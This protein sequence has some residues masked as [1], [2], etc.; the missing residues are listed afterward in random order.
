[1]EKPSGKFITVDGKRKFIR[2]R[3]TKKKTGDSKRFDYSSRGAKTSWEAVFTPILPE[4]DRPLYVA[5]KDKK[6]RS[7]WTQRLAEFKTAGWKVAERE[8]SYNRMLSCPSILHMANVPT[9]RCSAY[10]C[11]FCWQRKVI[12]IHNNLSVLFRGSDRQNFIVARSAKEVYK[13]AR[14]ISLQDLFDIYSEESIYRKKEIEGVYPQN[15]GARALFT[16]EP[17]EV[18]GIAHWKLH[19]RLLFLFDKGIDLSPYPH[20]HCMHSPT[21]EDVS[22][23]VAK[24]AEYPAG[25][26]LGDVNMAKCVLEV[27]AD[28]KYR[29]EA[30]YGRFRNKS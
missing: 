13:P 9:T 21:L 5:Q 27:R 2:Y 11:P 18:D 10:P 20:V 16:V 19:Y 7:I 8:L 1:M 12:H 4:G 3:S 15:I 30:S 14:D 26:M 17:A 25:L 6:V 23:A 22:R 29:T 24:F 28:G